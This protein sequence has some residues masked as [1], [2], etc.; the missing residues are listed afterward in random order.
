[1]PRTSSSSSGVEASIAGTKPR[2]GEEPGD[3]VGGR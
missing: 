1:M 3:V 2:R